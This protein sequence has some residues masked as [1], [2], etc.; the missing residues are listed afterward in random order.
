MSALSET[1]D[2]ISSTLSLLVSRHNDLDEK[3]EIMAE[4]FPEVKLE[5]KH[6]FAG[7]IYA[8]EVFIPKGT[9]L[10]SYTHTK[11]HFCL[12]TKG[13]ITVEGIDSL[14]KLIV[15]PAVLTSKPGARRQGYA[16]EDTVWVSMH[17]VGDET[18]IEKLEAE[19]YVEAKYLK[20]APEI[21]ILPDETN[22]QKEGYAGL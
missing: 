14:P 18:D 3:N 4:V 13:A 21:G 1:E 10:S 15:A 22:G 11:E 20:A 16:H 9:W 8:R 19:L 17:A 5:V 6:S 12:C 7:G 2:L